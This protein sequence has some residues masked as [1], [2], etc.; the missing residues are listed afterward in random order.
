MVAV[1]R[2]FRFWCKRIQPRV[3]QKLLQAILR[4]GQQLKA[5]LGQLATLG[6]IVPT[7]LRDPLY[8]IVANNRCASMNLI[9]IHLSWYS[10]PVVIF[11]FVLHFKRII[12]VAK[13]NCTL[14]LPS[15]N[16]S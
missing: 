5:P 3:L 1:I 9:N 15:F 2:P 10:S 6:F 16:T 4:I 7:F 8:D 11:C 14:L 12:F 13:R